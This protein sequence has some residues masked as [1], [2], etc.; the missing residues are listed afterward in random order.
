MNDRSNHGVAGSLAAEH[1]K[2]YTAMAVKFLTEEWAT[3][4]ND[5]LNSHD[6]FKSAIGTSDLAL[7]FETR[8]G[9]DGD[10]SYY[11]ETKGGSV[12]F[13]LGGL[14]NADVTVSQGYDTAVGISQG[15]INVQ[16]AFMT[17]KLKVQGNLAKLMMHTSAVAQWQAANKD[18]DVEY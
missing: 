18:L 17:G 13:A 12:A 7:Q 8:D 15:T 4:V 10:V 9:P 5:S 1:D 16:T 6:G 11:L 3:A 14:D 2:G